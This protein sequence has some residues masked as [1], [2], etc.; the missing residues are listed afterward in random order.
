MANSTGG[1]LPAHSPPA[2]T[3]AEETPAVDSRPDL[4]PEALVYIERV[5][6]ATRR[7]AVRAVEP[8]NIRQ[9]LEALNDVAHFDVEVPTASARRE[10]ELLK[11]GGKRLSAWYM[12]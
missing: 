7:L 1:D 4:G 9:S 10:V 12:R 5:R 11:T 3:Q 2:H 6:Q 8:A